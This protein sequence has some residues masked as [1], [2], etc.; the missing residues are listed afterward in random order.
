MRHVLSMMLIA[1]A[2]MAMPAAARSVR[3][4]FDRG[5]GERDERDAHE[6]TAIQNTSHFQSL[7]C[8]TNPHDPIR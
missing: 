5:S 4:N 7:T 6:F 3:D 8:S 2:G 1:V